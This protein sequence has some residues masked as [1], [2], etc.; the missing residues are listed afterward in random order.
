MI[1]RLGA[2]ALAATT[3]AVSAAAAQ[4]GASQPSVEEMEQALGIGEDEEEEEAPRFRAPSFEMGGSGSPSS[5]SSSSPSP[6]RSQAPR[7]FDVPIEFDFG[8]TEISR[9]FVPTI[10]RVAEVLQRNPELKLKIRGH[11]DDVGSAEANSELSQRRADAV[12]YAI[13]RR[14]IANSRLAAEGAGESMLIPG[15]DPSSRRNRR[16]EFLRTQ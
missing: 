8:S 14:G 16:V 9:T 7:S 1:G 11:T 10:D 4:E 15:V 2:I 6:G 13:V 3:L 5:Q 12:R